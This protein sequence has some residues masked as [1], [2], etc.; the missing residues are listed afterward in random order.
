[1]WI[2]V[3]M[4]YAALFF[5]DPYGL[6][7]QGLKREGYVCSV[8]WGISFLIA[9][10]LAMGWDLPSPSPLIINLVKRLY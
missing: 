4:A 3:V 9:F 1:M 6:F 8:L 10:A 7:T 5:I 2:L